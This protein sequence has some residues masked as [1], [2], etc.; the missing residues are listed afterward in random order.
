METPQANPSQSSGTVPTGGLRGGFVNAARFW[1]RKRL[2]YNFILTA[3]AVGWLV[4]TWPHFRPALTLDSLLKMIVLALLA[5]VCY[6]AAYL[7]DFALQAASGD[8]PEGTEWQASLGSQRWVLWLMGTALAFVFENYWIA[9]EIYP[10][11]H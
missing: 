7:V 8:K 3:V 10:D 1:E 2:Y 5:N 4:A 9:D 11:V 6:C